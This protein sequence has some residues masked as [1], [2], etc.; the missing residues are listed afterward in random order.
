MWMARRRPLL[1]HEKMQI[2]KWQ[3]R[4]FN[5]CIQILKTEEGAQIK[6]VTLELIVWTSQDGEEHQG[7]GVD[8]NLEE[9]PDPS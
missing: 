1:I 4:A 6:T 5:R 3:T 8:R 2:R 7:C 9:G